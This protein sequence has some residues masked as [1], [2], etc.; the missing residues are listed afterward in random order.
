MIILTLVVL[1][2]GPQAH[3]VGHGGRM[4]IVWYDDLLDVLLEVSRDSFLCAYCKLLMASTC[5]D[6]IRFFFV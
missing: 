2:G 5:F 1:T 6:S 3:D 4:G